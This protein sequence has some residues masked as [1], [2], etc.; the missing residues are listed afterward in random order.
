MWVRL[1]DLR[2]H[3]PNALLDFRW[4]ITKEDSAE[5]K[6][7]EL[8]LDEVCREYLASL[9]TLKIDTCRPYFLGILGQRY[10]WCKSGVIPDK[11]LEETFEN[12]S[13]RYPWIQKY[14]DRSITEIEMLYG[15]LFYPDL[16]SSSLFYLR[17]PSYADGKPDWR[18]Q[19]NSQEEKKV[20]RK[21]DGVCN[22]VV[23]PT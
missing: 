18:A 17:S 4:G 5:G 11:T 1:F 13:R 22:V 10:G 14:T 21:A 16:A 20:L 12:A 8:C 7:L 9:T 2:H 3:C 19:A 15:A 6:V 23:E